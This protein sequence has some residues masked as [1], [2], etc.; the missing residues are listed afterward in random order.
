MKKIRIEHYLAFVAILLGAVYLRLIPHIPN[1]TP[2]GALA[3]FSG[4]TIPNAAGFL[5]PLIVMLI[6]DSVIGFHDTIPYVYGSFLIISGIG[7]ILHKKITPLKIGL[8]SLVGSILFFIITNFGVWMT[9]TQYEGNG[10]GLFRTYVMGLPFFRNTLLGD[11]FYN[12]V[13]FI[14]YFFLVSI[15]KHIVVMVKRLVHYHLS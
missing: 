1:V 7:F 2:I 12:A 5:I 14:S 10:G 9:S 6:S 11:L 13:F 8:G 15:S 3:L 4:V